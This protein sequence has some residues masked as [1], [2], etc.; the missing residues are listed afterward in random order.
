M[1]AFNRRGLLVLMLV[2]GVGA[3]FLPGV[4]NAYCTTRERIQ[5]R[6][7]GVL[8]QEIDRLCG[9]APAPGAMPQQLP[10]NAQPA[11]RLPVAAVCVTNAG[12][13]PMAVAM[14]V[15]SACACYTQWG[16]VPGV[17]R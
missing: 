11:S 1:K 5:L 16:A 10:R 6:N 3:I 17:A 15:G 7:E 4:A 8:P 14:P 12:P 9:G 2:T 13:C